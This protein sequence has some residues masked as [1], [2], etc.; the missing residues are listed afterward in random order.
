VT[1]DP[2][3][4]RL[5][6]IGGIFIFMTFMRYSLSELGWVVFAPLLAAL[7]GRA[8]LRA[9]LAVLAVLVVA[10]LAAVSKMATAEIPWIPV[11][12]FAVPIALSYFAAITMSCAAHRRMG[13]RHGVYTF[14]AMVAVLGWIQ[15]SC[16]EAGRAPSRPSARSSRKPTPTARPSAGEAVASSG[17]GTI[18]LPSGA[19]APDPTRVTAR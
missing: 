12:M 8:T 14:A 17:A 1:R 11:P 13:P 2:M 4:K 10:F 18:W 3:P 5:L 19:G 15:Q 6:L 16:A 7:H 9:H